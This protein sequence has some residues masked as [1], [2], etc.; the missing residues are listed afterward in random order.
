MIKITETGKRQHKVSR[1]RGKK[2]DIIV[3]L[4]LKFAPVVNKYDKIVETIEEM[5]TVL[6]KDF[7]D[8]FEK[9]IKDFIKSG[10]DHK[11]IKDNIPQIKKFSVSYIDSLEI[12][13]ENYINKDKISKTSIFIDDIEIRKIVLVS[14]Y[15]K[16][17]FI[18]SQDQKMTLP[19]RCHKEIFK[20]LVK[21]IVDCNIIH[22]IFKIVSSKIYKYNTTDR[23]M[24]E[25][26]KLNLCKSTDIHIITI[27]NFVVNNILVA[28]KP[29]SN[30]IPFIISVI[31]SSIQWILRSVYKD[32]MLYVEQINTED[33]YSQQGRDNLKT[34]AYNDTIGRLILNSYNSL[35]D[36]GIVPDNFDNL[37]K[38]TSEKS[39]VATYLTFPIL[40]K[41]LDIPYRHLMTIPNQHAYLLN[42]LLY[43]V[44]PD[45]FKEKYPALYN[46]LI[47]YNTQKPIAKTT[48]AIKNIPH[49][50]ATLGTFIG[51][52]N[53]D[54]VYTFYSSILGK[55]VRNTYMNFKTNKAP[56]NLPMAKLEEDMIS[57]YNDYFDGRLDDFFEEIRVKL[58]ALL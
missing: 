52:K 26:I 31:D 20:E 46:L 56:S 5:S 36:M 19:Q 21:D 58:D 24:W 35:N 53:F 25:Y 37:V 17:Y 48:Y 42:I 11:V 14:N 55:M 23:Y 41:V 54:F 3:E 15:L 47:Y 43:Q 39:I 16:L 33:V 38:D 18:L 32:A 50:S 44:L 13:F 51:V 29:E 1:F 9:Y 10:Y 34:Y 4:Q 40:R 45:W 57:F 7:D 30:P 2:E 12:N 6:G 28:C 27:F 8:W 49:F 22:K